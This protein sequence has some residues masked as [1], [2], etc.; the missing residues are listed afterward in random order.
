MYKLLIVDDEERVCRGLK[1]ALD[2]SDYGIEIIGEAEDGKQA[3]EIAVRKKPHIIISDIYMP[4]MDGLEL[5]DK[6]KKLI[7]H[8]K[9]ILLSGYD[10]FSYAQKAV[11]N[12]AFDYVLKPIKIE[13]MLKIIEKA[14]KQIEIELSR[15]RDEKKLKQQLEENLPLLKE[16]YINYLLKNRFSLEQLNSNHQYLKINLK[17][18]YLIVMIIEIH[19]FEDYFMKDQQRQLNVLGLKKI[20][21]DYIQEDFVGGEVI[22]D[23]PEKLIVIINYSSDL[24]TIELTEK[25]EILSSKVKN[26]I[27]DNYNKKTTIGIGQP[28]KDSQHLFD[29]YQEARDALEYK[30][31]LGR[32]E[33][34]FFSDVGVIKNKSKFLYPIHKE[35][36]IVLALKIG[37]IEN[38]SQYTW[39]FI[40]FCQ[41]RKSI[42]PIDLRRNC[43]Q[44][45]YTVYKKLLEWDISFNY[46][47]FRESEVVDTI[48]NVSSI[49]ELKKYLIENLE[50]ITLIIK[51]K[52]KSQDKSIIRKACKFIENN[53][54]KDISLNDIADSVYLTP[55]YFTNQFKEATGKTVITYLTE[56]RINRAQDLLLNTQLKVYEIS[57][58]VGYKDA[59]Y[60]GQVFKKQVGLSP[61]QYRMAKA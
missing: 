39:E 13:N 7:P 11:R 22:E 60:F 50:K 37:D 35:E 40:K 5:T 43:L 2:W 16:K 49:T 59:K 17:N 30:I 45:I 54:D 26:I 46:N 32:G 38:I 58:K 25:L 12:K 56:T 55:N 23:F 57:R 21:V 10:K 4:G 19:K 41:E 3:L 52:R 14:K 6:I 20:I 34:I 33:T 1:A 47:D 18:Y 29:S 51:E 53:Y 9:V 36:K 8:T 48:K 42:S 24:E 15:L 27:Y 44:L 31:F 28:Y 61:N